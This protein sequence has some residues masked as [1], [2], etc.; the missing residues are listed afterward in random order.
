MTFCLV[1][2]LVHYYYGFDS[3]KDQSEPATILF[4]YLPDEG[5]I[6]EVLGF[7]CNFISTDANILPILFLS[8]VVLCL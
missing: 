1:G 5:T 8:V 4:D 6:G 3:G 2:A 7:G